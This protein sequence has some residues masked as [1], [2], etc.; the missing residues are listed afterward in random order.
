MRGE[1]PWPARILATG[2]TGAGVSASMTGTS[3]PMRHIVHL[4]PLPSHDDAAAVAGVPGYLRTLVP[5]Y[6]DA[7]VERQTIVSQAGSITSLDVP[8]VT[9][10]SSWSSGKREFLRSTRPVTAVGASVLH[11]QHEV[12]LYGGPLTAVQLPTV[13][14]RARR[15]GMATVTTIH[16]VIDL[17]GV[18]RTFVAENGSRLPAPVIR[19]AIRTL[20]GGTARASDIVIVHEELFRERLVTQYGIDP[21]AVRV[22]PLPSERVTPR[23]RDEALAAIGL[24]GPVVLFF[25]FVT[26]YKGLPTLIDAWRRHTAGGGI[27]ELV[28]AGGPH[29]RLSGQPAYDAEYAAMKAAATSLPR[30]RWAGYLDDAD[31]ATHLSAASLLVLPYTS[32][33]GA[34]GPLTHAYAHGLPAI[35]S[36]ALGTMAVHPRA[37][38]GTTAEDLAAAMSAALTGPLGDEL[39]AASRRAGEETR[40][41]AVA[42]RTVAIYD[43]AR[44]LPSRIPAGGRSSY[45]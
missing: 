16:G 35:M 9:V 5:A 12:F 14:K 30:V 27:G 21:A 1:P 40:L 26:G 29:P 37:V 23:P 43:E 45:P 11:T 33:L 32:A 4:S 19:R 36:D 2:R 3:N 28:I 6:A 8:G 39:A 20:I 44:A 15:H 7:G 34:S 22:V 24:T 25:G 13:L 10:R 42:R 31:A 38:Y 41:D 17:A 18:D